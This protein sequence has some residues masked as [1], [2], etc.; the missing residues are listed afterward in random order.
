MD[1]R[2]LPN[3]YLLKW[4][5]SPQIALAALNPGFQDP[6]DAKTTVTLDNPAYRFLGRSLMKGK[7]DWVLL[8]HIAVKDKHIGNQDFALSDHAWL[9]VDVVIPSQR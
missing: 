6:F 1:G 8:R 9:A 3:P 4:G 2:R 5:L 7:L